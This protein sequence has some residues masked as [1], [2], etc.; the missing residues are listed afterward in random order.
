M[1]AK[2]PVHEMWSSQPRPVYGRPWT[3]NFLQY[4]IPRSKYF[5]ILRSRRLGNKFAQKKGLMV[6][7]ESLQG[8]S[9][10]ANTLYNAKFCWKAATN[11]R[12]IGRFCDMNSGYTLVA[13]FETHQKAHGN[14]NRGSKSTDQKRHFRCIETQKIRAILGTFLKHRSR[15]VRHLCAH[16]AAKTSRKGF[17]TQSTHQ[18]SY[19]DMF[20]TNECMACV[21]CS[22]VQRGSAKPWLHE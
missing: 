4:G 16:Q 15:E 22:I 19:F 14:S 11:I 2:L 12:T 1:V 20:H 7:S 10:P 8:L 6:M 18:T 17:T 5:H 3:F 21:S 13:Q 9:S